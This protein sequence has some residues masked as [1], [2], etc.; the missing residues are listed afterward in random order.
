SKYK[1]KLL[2]FKNENDQTSCR[3]KSDESSEERVSIS[4][5]VGRQSRTISKRALRKPECR[6]ARTEV[7]E[8]LLPEYWLMS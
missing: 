1:K 5:L 8:G 2:K 3:L 7:P 6:F 4:Y